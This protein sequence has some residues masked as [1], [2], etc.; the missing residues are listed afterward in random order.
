MITKLSSKLLEII[1]E[2]NISQKPADL[3]LHCF[4]KQYMSWLSGRDS[5]RTLRLFLFMLNLTEHEIY[6]A[7]K[8]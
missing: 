4:L 1:K 7:H 8:C 6:H 3:D 5:D 2:K